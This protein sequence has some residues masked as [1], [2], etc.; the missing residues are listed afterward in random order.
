MLP[1]KRLTSKAMRDYHTFNGLRSITFIEGPLY[2][3]VSLLFPA[4]VEL[5]ETLEDAL[6]VIPSKKPESGRV[7]GAIEGDY[8]TPCR[9]G[10]G[11]LMLIDKYGNIL[12][13][14][15]EEF[16]NAQSK[17]SNMGD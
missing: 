7:E 8:R 2:K 16:I 5:V 10:F 4:G 14:T 6:I 12:E 15:M 1:M 13:L 11:N 17:Y 9:I 3:T